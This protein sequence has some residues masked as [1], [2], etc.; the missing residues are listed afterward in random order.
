[1]TNVG[2]PPPIFVMVRSGPSGPR[3][4]PRTPPQRGLASFALWFADSSHKDP[5]ALDA[6]LA[7]KRGAQRPSSVQTLNDVPGR[8]FGSLRSPIHRPSSVAIPPV[9]SFSWSSNSPVTP[10]HTQSPITTPV[11]PDACTPQLETPLPT[12]PLTN[13]LPLPVAK[14]PSQIL[15]ENDDGD[16]DWGEMISSPPGTNAPLTGLQN[17]EL[18]LPAASQAILAPAAPILPLLPTTATSILQEELLAHSSEPIQGPVLLAAESSKPIVLPPMP[19]ASADPWETVDLSAFEVQP[20]PLAEIPSSESA[21]DR[22][23]PIVEEPAEYLNH[24]PPTS[25]MAAMKLGSDV[26]PSSDDLAV[27]QD[28]TP[29]TPL[30]LNP[31]LPLPQ[32][33]GRAGS[34]TFEPENA[35]RQI[36]DNLPDLSYMLR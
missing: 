1:M 10:H 35:M 19:T 34:Q 25:L 31:P 13:S 16:D 20:T 5:M 15:A 22:P 26:P 29:M 14:P 32:S 18:A 27:E 23:A 12:K 9:A 21:T 24:A 11:P 8:I 3:L 7:K 4:E 33:E 30:E 17:F 6:A 2:G 28:F 36:I